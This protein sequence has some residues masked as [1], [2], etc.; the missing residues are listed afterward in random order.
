M[1]S[2]PIPAM[3]DVYDVIA[4]Q[5]VTLY[6]SLD[7]RAGYQKILLNPATAHKTAFQTHE[8]KFV[9]NRLSFGLCNAVS[10]FRWLSRIF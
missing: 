2:W 6:S 1:T 3:A 10:F 4:Q 5:K 9:H 8:G 7:L